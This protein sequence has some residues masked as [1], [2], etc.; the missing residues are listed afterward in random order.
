MS[1][2]R[3]APATGNYSIDRLRHLQA[4]RQALAGEEQKLTWPIERLHTLRDRRLRALLHDAKAR[5]PWHA[6]R[7]QHVDIDNLSGDDLTCIP[8]M[9]KADLIANWDDIVTDRRLTLELANR[10]LERVA[11]EGPTYL[12]DQ[13]HV[14][15]SGGTTGQRAVFAW[16][17]EGWLQARL[18]M[19]R[20]EQAAARLVG[21]RG[22]QR[23][24]IVAAPNPV[25]ASGALFQTFGS[26]AGTFRSIPST[27]PMEQI[28]AQLNDYCPD[29]VQTYPS[30]LRT[31]TNEARHGRLH[32]QPK[33]IMC[34]GEP[35][36]AEVR[37]NAEATF[38]AAIID[39]YACS[40]TSWIAV[41]FPNAG[42][43]LHL[44]EDAAVYEP[45][46]ALH[47]SVAPGIQAKG[48]L[49]TNVANRLLPLIRYELTDG[50]TLLNET[51]PGPWTGRRIAP[52]HGRQEQV[53]TYA[54]G[55]EINPEV[56][57]A[58]LD[59]VSAVLESQV[60]QSDKGAILRL[61]VA[62]DANLR[63][64]AEDLRA[65]LRSHGLVDPE[66]SIKLVDHLNGQSGT[67]KLNRFVAR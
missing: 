1:A 59:R 61:S 7:L 34:G 62:G 41:S 14:I 20:H 40:E 52:V 17:F 50:V 3:V 56:F 63:P 66:I 16:D 55:V 27:L 58:A 47:R 23:L 13:Y 32:L 45:V 60:E 4:F 64:L 37:A 67:G 39:V 25:H 46:D 10:H 65:A 57:D 48:L 31:L 15:A 30:A 12:L 11:T 2:V 6:R 35:L 18:V 19:A 43:P 53:F 51:N 38:G 33:Y 9:T 54:G 21:E 22:V 28:V 24:G 36:T 42:A 44:I 5:S 29:A 49:V 26:A 8:P